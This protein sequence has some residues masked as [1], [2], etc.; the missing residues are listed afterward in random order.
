MITIVLYIG[1]V[2]MLLGGVSSVFL[3]CFESPG[4]FGN[5]GEKFVYIG[6]VFFIAG[7]L[8]ISGTV[9]FAYIIEPF[10]LPYI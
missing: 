9:V 3:I 6:L 5:R 10:V 1:V 8:L 2:L 7:G 4:S